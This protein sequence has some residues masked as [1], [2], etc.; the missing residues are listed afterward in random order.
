MKL[1]VAFDTLNKP[2]PTSRN[3]WNFS[4]SKINL[5]VFLSC[6]KKFKTGSISWRLELSK[7][8]RISRW[9][10]LLLTVVGL[11]FLL[12]LISLSK[13]L[14]PFDLLF[15]SLLLLFLSSPLD[16]LEYKQEPWG[17]FY[18]ELVVVTA[19]FLPRLNCVSHF[20][21]SS[22]SFRASSSYLM[23]WSSSNRQLVLRDMCDSSGV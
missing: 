8:F 21:I 7:S 9:I 1:L 19:L 2:Q 13:F 16:F 4:G 5:S 23:N 18:L 22:L 6:S 10:V 14:H 20:L 11:F 15:F 17:S 3:L 12:A